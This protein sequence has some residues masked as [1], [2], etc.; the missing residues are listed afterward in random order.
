M[1]VH[2]LTLIPF[3][4][5]S[6]ENTLTWKLAGKRSKFNIKRG[7]KLVGKQTVGCLF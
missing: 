3:P 6:P 4:Q 1:F 5:S 7:A 2:P